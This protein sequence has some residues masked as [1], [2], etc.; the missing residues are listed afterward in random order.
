VYGIIASIISAVMLYVA[1]KDMEYGYY[2]FLRFAVMFTSIFTAYV[3]YNFKSY[4]ISTVSLLIAM[5]FN[6]FVVVTLQK[7]SWIPIDLVTALYFISIEKID[8]ERTINI[9]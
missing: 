9:K 6:P 1:T 5:L 4:V 2:T 7:S 3:A 8:Q